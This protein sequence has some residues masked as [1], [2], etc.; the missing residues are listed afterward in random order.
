MSMQYGEPVPQGKPDSS[1][2]VV[3]FPW[4]NVF[5]YNFDIMNTLHEFAARPM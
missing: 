2:K 1:L 5:D 3:T 4:I